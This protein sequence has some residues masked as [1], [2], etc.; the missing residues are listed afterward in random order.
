VKAIFSG[1]EYQQTP[2]YVRIMIVCVVVDN[3]QSASQLC[4]K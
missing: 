2:Y 3:N 1:V 4:F